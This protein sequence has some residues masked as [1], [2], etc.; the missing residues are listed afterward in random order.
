MRLEQET[1]LTN[2]FQNVFAK[3]YTYLW[4][5]LYS[6]SA[7]FEQRLFLFYPFF[8][9]STTMHNLLLDEFKEI[10]VYLQRSKT[11]IKETHTKL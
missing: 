8:K 7:I 1:T 2:F 11:L 10:A 6:Y 4:A 3:L 5:T 9:S